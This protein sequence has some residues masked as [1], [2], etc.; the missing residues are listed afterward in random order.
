MYDLLAPSEPPEPAALRAFAV[1]LTVLVAVTTFISLQWV[2][3]E[4]AWW[5]VLS[6]LVMVHP[7]TDATRSRVW[8]RILGTVA[9]GV[10]AALIAGAIGLST[11]TRILGG[12]VAVASVL[13][14][15]KAPYWV[16]SALLTAALVLLTVAPDTL[17][18]SDAERIGFTLAGGLAVL[19][20]GVLSSLIISAEDASSSGAQV[21]RT[22]DPGDKGR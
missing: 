14:H 4:H 9:G 2:Q 10:V 19:L 15:F 5:I 12:I 6:L 16:F 8:H 21:R 13:A 17:L 1:T 3:L 7:D 11:P 22:A 18:R 20:A